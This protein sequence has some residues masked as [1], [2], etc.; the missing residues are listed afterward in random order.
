MRFKI[1][2]QEYVE[3]A[4]DSLGGSVRE[5][6]QRFSCWAQPDTDNNLTIK[7]RN[8]VKKGMQVI[9]NS[10]AFIIGST[11]EIDDGGIRL[12]KLKFSS[13]RGVTSRA[14]TVSKAAPLP[15]SHNEASDQPAQ[16]GKGI[17]IL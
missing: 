12:L 7:Y 4:K 13:A 6:R 11:E 1:E 8:D 3:I 10:T 9:L 16:A 5:W 17:K 15:V 2:I 14:R